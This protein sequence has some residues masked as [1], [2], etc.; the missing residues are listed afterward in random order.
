MEFNS[1][2]EALL[3]AIHELRNAL[4]PLNIQGKLSERD[5][6][7]VARGLA[8]ATK[9][10]RHLETTPPQID[11]YLAAL[12]ANPYLHE[13]FENL[14]D[15]HGEGEELT[16]RGWTWLPTRLSILLEPG[17]EVFTNPDNLTVILRNIH[18]DRDVGQFDYTVRSHSREAVEAFL[19]SFRLDISLITP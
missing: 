17:E 8:V 6:R 7:G 16:L 5:Q 14:I 12:G 15:R 13:E 3:Y 1:D 11:G 2:R 19:H 9:L 18:P 10:A 4:V